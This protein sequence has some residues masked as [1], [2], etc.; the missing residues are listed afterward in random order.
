MC[1][2][3]QSIP[4][5][6]DETQMTSIREAGHLNQLEHQ[7]YNLPQQQRFIRHPES[8]QRELRPAHPDYQQ[9]PSTQNQPRP[10]DQQ[11]YSYTQRQQSTRPRTSNYQQQTIMRPPYLSPGQAAMSAR[12]PYMSA[13]QPATFARPPY[14]SPGQPAMSDNDHQKAPH[15]PPNARKQLPCV[16]TYQPRNCQQHANSRPVV[17]AGYYEKH[18]IPG[19]SNIQQQK[20]CMPSNFEQYYDHNQSVRPPSTQPQHLPAPPSEQHRTSTVP[21]HYV[22][23]EYY[24]PRYYNQSYYE[25]YEQELPDNP[26]PTESLNPT[27][28]NYLA[29]AYNPGQYDGA[30]DYNSVSESSYV[31]PRAE[32]VPDPHMSM[33]DTRGPVAH[34]GPYYPTYQSQGFYQQTHGICNDRMQ[35]PQHRGMRQT[36]EPTAY[37]HEQGLNEAGSSLPHSHSTGE[38]IHHTGQYSDAQTQRMGELRD[39]RDHRQAGH[40]HSTGE[41]RDQAQPLARHPL[42]H[43]MTVMGQSTPVPQP[44]LQLRTPHSPPH[45]T[46]NDDVE[47]D[48]PL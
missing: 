47:V 3:F 31:K 42:P 17:P 4:S 22:T 25:Q 35:L 45:D 13:G 29:E 7:N 44:M 8:H 14:L 32:H 9:L 6:M 16:P 34:R 2:F 30:V 12:P 28:L 46:S 5:V 48:T 27:A 11:G 18:E 41:V 40:G 23:Q 26:A 37:P 39:P 38:L 24:D 1:L 10:V 36:M 21:G 43:R 33:Y 20:P 19:S 15:I